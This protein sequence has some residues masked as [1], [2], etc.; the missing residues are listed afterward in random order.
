MKIKQTVKTIFVVLALIGGVVS[1]A[2][3]TATFADD[4]N[5]DTSLPT[6]TNGTGTGA[7]AATPAA[8]NSSSTSSAYTSG[9]AT[10]TNNG[11]ETN[12]AIIKCTGV[13]GKSVEGTGLWSIL[14]LAIDILSAGVAVAAVGGI[15]YGAILYTSAGGSEEPVKKA[16][17]IIQNVVIGVIAYALMYGGLNFLIPGGLFN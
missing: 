7:A 17:G 11:C 10:K 8:A 3:P 6:P 9:D 2:M 5:P 14:L 15:V 13:T 16:M 12:T 1:M 4:P